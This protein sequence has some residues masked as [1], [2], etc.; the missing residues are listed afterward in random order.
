MT[1]L[2]STDGFPGAAVTKY[3]KQVLKTPEIDCFSVLEPRS[4]KSRSQQVTIPLNPTRG[5][6]SSP[7]LA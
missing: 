3:H 7:L 5:N 1:E 6:P 4:L 2:N